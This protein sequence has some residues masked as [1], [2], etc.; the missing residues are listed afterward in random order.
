MDPFGAPGDGLTLFKAH[1]YGNDF[2]MVHAD[3][4]AGVGDRASLA[5]AVCARHTGIG[6]D[7]LMVVT[8]TSAGAQMQLLNADGS[9]SELSGNGIRCI[10]A[11]LAR[12]ADSAPGATI[13]IETDAGARPIEILARDGNTVLCRT[14][15]G[16]ASG[17]QEVRL[18][19]AGESVSCVVL[20]MGNPQ[21][22]VLVDEA[23][24][25]ADRLHQLG[26]ALAVHPF[27]PAGTNVELAH[28][29]GPSQVEILIWERGVGPTESSGTGTCAA[30]VAATR[31]GGADPVLTVSAPGGV[32]RVEIGPDA[33]WLTGA[34]EVLGRVTWWGSTR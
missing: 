9:Y 20:N 15:M 10:A 33:V 4:V 14:N 31:F 5:R 24:L 16:T 8:P 25:T 30:A 21:C 11:T 23:G 7:G 32:Q 18:E 19:V 1:A 27:F 29:A 22:V 17:V 2:L 3:H 12:A 28:V 13:V 6:A 34:A 26:G